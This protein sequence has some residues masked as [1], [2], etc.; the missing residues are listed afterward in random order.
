L[1]GYQVQSEP[2]TLF[3]AIG[4][5]NGNVTNAIKV[6]QNV[7]FISCLSSL[8]PE[9]GGGGVAVGVHPRTNKLKDKEVHSLLLALS[10]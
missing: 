4:E 8:P 9:M 1:Y 7:T 3:L 2:R 6:H 5:I 10:F